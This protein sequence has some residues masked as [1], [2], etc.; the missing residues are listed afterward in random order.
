LFLTE[1][2]YDYQIEILDWWMARLS[3][4]SVPRGGN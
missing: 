2:G 1:Q 4:F 3:T